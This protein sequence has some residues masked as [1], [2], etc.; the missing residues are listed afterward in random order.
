MLSKSTENET[1]YVVWENN[2]YIYDNNIYNHVYHIWHSMEKEN[3]DV[4][5]IARGLFY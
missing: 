1:I 3:Y 4:I 5:E 2:I